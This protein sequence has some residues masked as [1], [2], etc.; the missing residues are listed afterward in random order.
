MVMTV[1]EVTTAGLVAAAGQGER[2]AWDQLVD[3]YGGLVFG[4]ARSF[5]LST[6]DAADVS[7]TVWLRFAEHIDRLREPERAGAWLATTT[8]HECMRL[9]RTSGRVVISDDLGGTRDP[10]DPVEADLLRSERRAAVR[11]AFAH[12][13]E[14]CQRL[15]ALLMADEVRPYRELAVELDMPVGGIGPTRARC[16]EHLRRALAVRVDADDVREDA[17]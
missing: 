12:I 2:A 11:E 5:R 1:L 4:V 10:A 14:R 6:A 9:L 8:R 3:R 16:L 7:Q 17:P 15:L 13:P